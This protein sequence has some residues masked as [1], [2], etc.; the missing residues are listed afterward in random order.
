MEAAMRQW[1][2]ES[3]MEEQKQEGDLDTFGGELVGVAGA[4]TLQQPMPLQFSQIIAELVEAVG[5][6]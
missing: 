5:C 1:P 4:I 2:A 6:V 3:L